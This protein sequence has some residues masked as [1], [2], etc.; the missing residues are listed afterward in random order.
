MENR[1]TNLENGRGDE[2]QC[3]G[4]IL[5]ELLAQYEGRWAAAK[6]TIMETPEDKEDLSC[7][8]YPVA[9]ANVS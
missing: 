8:F 2:P 6:V 9:W 5:A 3:I 7:L 4:D 1:I